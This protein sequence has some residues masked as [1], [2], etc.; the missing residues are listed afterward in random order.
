MGFTFQKE[1]VTND[2]R[3]LSVVVS[4][5]VL[6]IELIAV[7]TIDY[8]RALCTPSY[9]FYMIGPICGYHIPNVT[10]LL[11]RAQC[12]MSVIGCR[13]K[14]NARRAFNL[15]KAIEVR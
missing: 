3:L 14:Y 12:G 6:K 13:R 7:T 4:A 10:T 8:L 15:S 9:I 1:E 5:T 11:C 2:G